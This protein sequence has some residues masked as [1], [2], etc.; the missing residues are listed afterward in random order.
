MSLVCRS[1]SRRPLAPRRAQRRRS[2]ASAERK[3]EEGDGVACNQVAYSTKFANSCQNHRAKCTFEE[4]VRA[5]QNATTTKQLSG[6]FEGG[7]GAGGGGGTV[8]PR[9]VRY[10]AVIEAMM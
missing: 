10:A 2:E 8:A 3:R 4:G 7:G 9:Y 6:A 1:Q 5:A